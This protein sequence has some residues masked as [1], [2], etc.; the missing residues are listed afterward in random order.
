MKALCRICS[1]EFTEEN[2]V[3]NDT[4]LGIEGSF[5]YNRCK[6]CG[7]VQ[8]NRLPD[9]LHRFYPSEYCESFGLAGAKIDNKFKDFITK[10]SFHRYPVIYNILRFFELLDVRV[11]TIRDLKLSK[12]SRILDV[13]AGD[14]YFLS[15]LSLLGFNHIQGLEPYRTKS[16]RDKL[17]IIQSTMVNLQQNLTFDVIIYNDSFEHLWDPK[18]ELIE[19]YKHLNPEGIIIIRLP[20]ASNG[21]ESFKKYWFELDPP[22]HFYLHTIKSL[23]ILS[24]ISNFK[25]KSIDYDSFGR[26]Y[27][28]SELNRKGKYFK[29]QPLFFQLSGELLKPSSYLFR[30][31][32][33]MENKQEIGNH[34]VIILGKATNTTF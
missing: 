12:N 27:I 2:F 7:C 23:K 17:N 28:R 14:G 9:N 13:G 29:D 32:A 16:V 33:K 8:I 25:I 19:L 15:A 21:F 22:R 31:R 6:S 24:E 5:T 10:V 20:L 3:T 1:G 4:M 30:R 11:D 34:A 18:R 26:S